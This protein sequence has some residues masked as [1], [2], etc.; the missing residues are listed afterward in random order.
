MKHSALN[1]MRTVSLTA[2]ARISAAQNTPWV[3]LKD[4]RS[5]VFVF[6]GRAGRG[7][8]ADDVAVTFQQAKTSGGGE[9]KAINPRRAIRR[10]GANLAAAMAATPEEIAG[11][12]RLV[13]NGDGFTELVVEFDA[14]ELDVTNDFA[15]VRAQTPAVASATRVARF[16]A[17]LCGPRYATDPLY[18]ANPLA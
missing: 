16:D 5:V 3:S 12:Q 15:Y 2:E 10:E 17:I 6:T 4:Y 8:A 13:T 1:E 9:A 7:A 11:D 18:L 14:A